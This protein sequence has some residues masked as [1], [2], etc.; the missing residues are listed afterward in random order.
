MILNRANLMIIWSVFVSCFFQ[1]KAFSVD[2]LSEDPLLALANSDE[3]KYEDAVS[4]RNFLRDI[5]LA[6][7]KSETETARYMRKA[8]AKHPKIFHKLVTKN[9]LNYWRE[10]LSIADIPV[11]MD[12]TAAWF[13][14][15]NNVVRSGEISKAIA[16]FASDYAS[17]YT[18]LW[19]FMRYE[20]RIQILERFSDE[21]FIFISKLIL[22][23]IDRIDFSNEPCLQML[24][25][26]QQGLSIGYVPD[27]FLEFAYLLIDQYFNKYDAR[28]KSLIIADILDLQAHCSDADKLA[29]FLNGSGPVVQKFFQLMGEHVESEKISKLVNRL[30]SNVK[31]FSHKQVKKILEASYNKPIEKMFFKFEKKP[32]ASATIA[33]VHRALLKEHSKPIVVKVRRPN[34]VARAKKEI[35]I[36]R[37]LTQCAGILKITDK[38]EKI[39]DEETDLQMEAGYLKSGAIYNRK[40]KG[41]HAVKL[42]EEYP[43]RPGVIMMELANGKSIH[44]FNKFEDLKRKS[45]GLKRLYKIWLREA[46]FGDGF[47]HADLHSGNLFYKR[48]KK[49]PGYLLTLLDFGSVGKLNFYERKALV[50]LGLGISME[51]AQLVLLGFR[52]FEKMNCEQAQEYY[53]VVENIL[54]QN[55][56]AVEKTNQ[57]LDEALNREFSLSKNFLQFNR[58]KAFLEDMIYKNN[59]DLS[60]VGGE[61]WQVSSWRIYS[62]MIMKK[63]PGLLNKSLFGNLNKPHSPVDKLTLNF[64]WQYVKQH[65]FMGH[66]KSG[67][68]DICEGR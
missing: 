15:F 9:S 46:F 33:Q 40:G 35:A 20:D 67:D 55:S 29:A 16:D 66:Y 18:G 61:K 38:L 23:L 65:F 7:S 21:S 36:I 51:D 57:I 62:K 39:I 50:K 49:S 43:P 47:F 26:P 34:I 28:E 13:K 1:E 17:K 45:I 27:S 8:I 68:F 10:V 59:K 54:G 32:L 6:A 63:L 25:D 30:K 11:K 42:I 64:T 58:G 22:K 31:P 44:K 2:G 19:E 3:Q 24:K 53:K 52:P 12:S 56:N 41:I 5:I 4:I 48:R 14:E 37:S 60:A